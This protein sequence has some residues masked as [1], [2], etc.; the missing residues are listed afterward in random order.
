[1]KY[2]EVLNGYLT[3]SGIRIPPNTHA[4]KIVAHSDMD[5]FFSA[6]LTYHQLMKQGIDGKNITINFVQYGDEESDLLKKVSS[7]K[8]Q[9]VLH[10]LFGKAGKT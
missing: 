7:K 9:N 5:G 1:M 2:N 3:E 10:K 6:L 8:G 4:A